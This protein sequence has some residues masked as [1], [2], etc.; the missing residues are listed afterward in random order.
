MKTCHFRARDAA[1]G[2]KVNTESEIRAEKG[3]IV[4]YL[5]RTI[6][7]AATAACD[8]VSRPRPFGTCAESRNQRTHQ[9]NR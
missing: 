1:R 9:Q 6:W 2:S 5:L 8:R 7:S 4:A 3:L